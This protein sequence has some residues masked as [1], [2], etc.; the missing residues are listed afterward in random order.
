[1][2][3]GGAWG[4]YE[5]NLEISKMA[6]FDGDSIFERA[7]PAHRIGETRAR[8]LGQIPWAVAFTWV[9]SFSLFIIIL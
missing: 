4:K 9:D 2:T 5:E 3:L 8:W 7:L 1:M 6:T